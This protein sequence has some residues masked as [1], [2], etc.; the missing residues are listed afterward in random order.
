MEHWFQHI[1]FVDLGP[2]T[3]WQLSNFQSFVVNHF[4]ITLHQEFVGITLG[5]NACEIL[6]TRYLKMEL[7]EEVGGKKIS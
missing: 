7:K 1:L 6:V 2:G 4:H 5:N 3:N